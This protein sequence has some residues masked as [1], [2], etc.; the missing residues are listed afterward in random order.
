MLLGTLKYAI[1]FSVIGK[2]LG[3][4]AIVLAVL[5]LPPLAAAAMDGDVAATL[6]YG[7][8]LAALLG[9]GLSFARRPTPAFIQGNEALVIA[10]LAFIMGAL[11]M[12]FP[13]MSPGLDWLDAVFESTSAI[14]TTGLTTL[15]SVEDKPRYFLFAR[16]WQQWYGGLGIVVLSV[17]L[18]ASYDAAARQL[19]DP[20]ARLENLDTSAQLFARRASATYV[21]LTLGGIAALWLAGLPLF[22][23]LTHAFAAIS[24]GG[25]STHDA[26]LAAFSG[27]TPRL[28][29]MGLS[30]AGAVALPLYFLAWRHGWRMLAAN[31]E[32][33]ALLVLCGLSSALLALL[34]YHA[35]GT[36]QADFVGHA[37]LMATSAQT[38]TGFASLPVN[39]LDATAKLVLI[40]SMLVGGSVG[41]TAG[42]F[43]LW[44]LLL[45]LRLSQLVFRRIA[46]P[47]HAV[48]EL[49]L[50]GRVI[51]T[52]ELTRGLWLM[53]LFAT[54]V[55]CSWFPFLWFGCDPM[56]ALFEVV[57]ALATTGLSAGIASPDLHPLLK[58]ILCADMLLGRLEIIAVLVLFAPQTWF[59]RRRMRA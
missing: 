17:A 2:Y 28:V 45:L 55:L 30:L 13:L 25:F 47:D 16:A 18:L 12:A 36:W 35:Q 23:A 5:A 43:K 49:R 7:L 10:A 41:S 6:R 57:S 19:L 56:N 52:D 58:G 53:L 48:V 11:M 14:T 42:G 1:R 21:A 33:H 34:L 59:G 3:Q 40:L 4:L 50:G 37:V 24:T 51:E 15:A 26:S 22:D 38:T 27:W 46:M 8:V 20:Q 31:V 54:V 44:R 9:I 29:T 32:L 39:N